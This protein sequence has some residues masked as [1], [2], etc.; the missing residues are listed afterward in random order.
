MI[1]TRAEKLLQIVDEVIPLAL[2]Y[3]LGAVT[4]GAHIAHQVWQSKRRTAEKIQQAGLGGEHQQAKRDLGNLRRQ[5]YLGLHAP[6]HAETIK[7]K[8]LAQK[9][10][11]KDIENRGLQHYHATLSQNPTEHAAAKRQEL[12]T[13]H[14]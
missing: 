10:K 1:I 2:P 13:Q 9:Q 12:L 14:S 6:G 8:Y 5:N 7:K 3:A 4:A 11:V